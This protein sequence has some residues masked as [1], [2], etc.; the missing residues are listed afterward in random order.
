M[1]ESFLNNRWV[2]VMIT[3]LA[4]SG[5]LITFYAFFQKDSPHIRFS[6]VSDSNVL[7]IKTDISK[8]DVLYDSSSLKETHKNLR[9]YTIKVV[10]LGGA[11]V[12]K[13]HFDTNAP[14]GLRVENGTIIEKPE[15]IESSSDYLINNLRINRSSGS[16]ITFSEII[17][18][19]DEFF[20]IKLLVLHPNEKQP[21]LVPTGKI[22][23]QKQ[24]AIEY[25][26]TSNLNESI[27]NRSFSGN[28]KVQLL[29]S[30]IYT[31]IVIVTLLLILIVVGQIALLSQ[32]WRRKSLVKEFKALDNYQHNKMNEMIFSEFI[33]KGVV[34]LS[35]IYLTINDLQEVNRIY[36]EHQEMMKNAKPL[37]TIADQKLLKNF[38][39]VENE[40][41]LI[42]EAINNGFLINIDNHL[43]HNEKLIV[44]IYTF[45]HF[46]EQKKSST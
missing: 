8:L 16:E 1:V 43:V 32:K 6:I 20:S 12:L 36:Q 39:K 7:D 27:W 23:G 46:I 28:L 37:L 22:A 11:D 10:N 21:N 25:L 40:I 14:L 17:I 33:S 44:L 2:K 24:I 3:I 34:R 19:S 5:T 15:I 42:H 30:L 29:R 31:L 45:L 4:I 38:K 26:S 9:I 18:E 41:G 13:G 35:K